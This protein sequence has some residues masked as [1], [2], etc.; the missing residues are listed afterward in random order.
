M[1]RKKSVSFFEDDMIV[2]ISDT[3]N[4]TK[5]LLEVI[6]TSSEVAGYKINFKNKKTKIVAL[7]YTNDRLRKKSGE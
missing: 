7:L 3:Q 2:Y 6:N 1:E 4:S 5:E